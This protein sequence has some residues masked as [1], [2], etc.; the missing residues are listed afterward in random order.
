MGIHRHTL[1]LLPLTII[2]DEDENHNQNE[3]GCEP[4]TSR[5][6]PAAK[7]GPEDAGGPEAEALAQHDQWRRDRD[8]K[9]GPQASHRGSFRLLKRVCNEQ[10]QTAVAAVSIQFR[11]AE[12]H[13]VISY[14]GLFLLLFF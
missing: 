4:P 10:R 11:V 2:R 7:T 9:R 13:I 8:D 14:T 5:Y 12:T 3:N 1:L 6:R